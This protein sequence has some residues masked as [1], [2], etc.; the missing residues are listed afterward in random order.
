MEREKTTTGPT[1]EQIEHTSRLLALLELR[2]ARVFDVLREGPIDPAVPLATHETL[3]DLEFLNL[4][5]ELLHLPGF[6]RTLDRLITLARRR[7]GK[8]GR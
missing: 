5:C 8:R 2:G 3:A 4:L 7:L 1:R 6:A